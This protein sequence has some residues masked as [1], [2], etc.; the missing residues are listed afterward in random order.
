MSKRMVGFRADEQYLKKIEQLSEKLKLDF[1]NTVRLSVDKMLEKYLGTEEEILL[2]EDQKFNLL[3]EKGLD[4]FSRNITA[5]TTSP[6]L[7]AHFREFLKVVA[8][9]VKKTGNVQADAVEISE[10]DLGKWIDQAIKDDSSFETKDAN[11]GAERVKKAILTTVQR[12]KG[13][14]E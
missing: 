9:K 14:I 10:V 2:I 11:P 6:G 13:R 3:V 7:A 4:L 1:S 8:S 5:F 12:L